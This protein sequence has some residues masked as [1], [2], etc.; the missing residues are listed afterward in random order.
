MAVGVQV[1]QGG[2]EGV[3]VGVVAGHSGDDRGSGVVC[4]VGEG[5]G[6]HRVWG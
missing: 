5:G 3:E 6:Q 4:D 2:G 1:G